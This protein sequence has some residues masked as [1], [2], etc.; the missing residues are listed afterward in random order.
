M[1]REIKNIPLVS[2]LV[3]SVYLD[4]I[5]H[6]QVASDIS[7]YS[8]G[9]HEEA[10]EYGWISRG[11]VQY[12]DMIIPVTPEITKLENAVTDVLKQ[13]TKR[14]YE[15][16]E[17]WAIR[18]LQGQSV[19]AHSHYSNL[20]VHPEEYYSVAYYPQVPDGSA[21]LIFS[22][23][24]CGVRQTSVPVPPQKGLLLV[25]NSYITHM[26]ARQRPKDPR[27]VVS[28]NLGP[29]EP[30]VTPNADWSVY[31]NRPVVDNPRPAHGE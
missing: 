22:A 20:H 27:L 13:L 28:M 8:R 12:E 14:D 5:D 19:I 23:N 17:T 11:F 4:D 30:N 29:V 3:H 26:T 6:D 24:W 9:V 18:L 16:Y 2:Q 7:H 10:P 31:L 1:S 15:I 21:E 25:F